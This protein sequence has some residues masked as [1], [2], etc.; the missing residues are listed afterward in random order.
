MGGAG[1]RATGGPVPSSKGEDLG[2][3]KVCVLRRCWWGVP[4]GVGADRREVDVARVEA[5]GSFVP[6]SYMGRKRREH[7]GRK[8]REH[9]CMG[10]L[11][12]CEV[13]ERK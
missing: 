5:L 13:D 11:G 4:A 6:D 12:G 1:E 7:Q 2:K 3:D 8:R 9:Q 10:Q